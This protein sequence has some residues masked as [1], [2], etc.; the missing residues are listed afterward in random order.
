MKKLSAH[1]HLVYL[2]VSMELIFWLSYADVYL[3]QC[4]L[5]LVILMFIYLIVTQC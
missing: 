2:F 4:N 5:V 3:S 1:I